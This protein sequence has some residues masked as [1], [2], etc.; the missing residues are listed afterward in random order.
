MMRSRIRNLALITGTVGLAASIPDVLP[1]IAN[2]LL[3][4]V[5]VGMIIAGPMGDLLY[6]ASRSHAPEASPKEQLEKMVQERRNL[7]AKEHARVLT[8]FDDLISKVAYG[9]EPGV[10][11]DVAKSFGRFIESL[12]AH[13]PEWDSEGRL[14]TFILLK[15]I[16]QSLNIRNADPYL[17][18][19][20]RTLLARGNEATDIS[21]IALNGTVEK[22][23]RDPRSGGPHRLAGTLLLMNRGN[24]EYARQMVID[25]IHLWSD[26][27][28]KRLKQDFAT[29]PTLGTKEEESIVSLLE[30]EMEKA[31]RTKDRVSARRAKELWKTVLLATPRPAPG[32]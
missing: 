12:T 19:A 27:R 3:L 7:S 21:H 17:D 4:G 13:Y 15:E 26:T 14:R 6:S 31:N 10:N 5:S 32:E 30:K 28:F 8:D 20:Y 2:A 29:V 25:A 24:D 9:Q 22:I 1:P 18:I 11:E 23:Y 16:E